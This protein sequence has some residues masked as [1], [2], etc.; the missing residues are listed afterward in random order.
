MSLS[1]MDAVRLVGYLRVS[2]EEQGKSGLGL[3]AQRK[4]IRRECEHRGWELVRFEEDIASGKSANGR[5]GLKRALD[6]CSS[7]EVEGLITAKLD[8]LSRSVVDFG[9]LIERA[10]K[11]KWDIVVLDPALDLSTP[12][13]RLCA[14]VLVQVAQWEREIIADRIRDALAEAKKR[15]PQDLRRLSKERGRTVKPIGNPGFKA[16]PPSLVKR[17]QALRDQGL[18]LRKI[19]G[20]LERDGVKTAQGGRWQA[21]T[22]RQIL[23]RSES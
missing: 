14:G 11:E 8:R 16:V 18:S 2:T 7:G 23:K 5:P 20:T 12:G 22:V 13:G 10:Q 17:I 21:E 6:S 3:E 15:T 4:A 9:N 19:A 1:T